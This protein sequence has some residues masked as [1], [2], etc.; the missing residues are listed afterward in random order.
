[1]TCCEVTFFGKI[2]RRELCLCKDLLDISLPPHLKIEQ[3]SVVYG[4]GVLEAMH[5][6]ELSPPVDILGLGKSIE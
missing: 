2:V 4:G 6:P 3:V 1:M 5:S